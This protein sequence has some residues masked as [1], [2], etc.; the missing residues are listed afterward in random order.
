M[1]SAPHA[2]ER[3]LRPVARSLAVGRMASPSCPSMTWAER[4]TVEKS[5][6]HWMVTDRF[7]GEQCRLLS[8]GWQA[9]QMTCAAAARA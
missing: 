9:R 5:D 7:T 1:N 2:Q 6:D 8:D 3:H 4:H